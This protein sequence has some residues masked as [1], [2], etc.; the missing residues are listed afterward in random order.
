MRRLLLTL[1][2]VAMTVAVVAVA[3]RVARADEADAHYRSGLA[4]KKQNKTDEAIQEFMA[5]IKLRS[6]Y[7]AA[8]FSLGLTYKMRNQLAKA[9]DLN[10][11]EA[12]WQASLGTIYREKKEFGK[13]IPHLEKA[14]QLD[15]KDAMALS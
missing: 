13:A 1:A 10:P 15:P 11:N 4:L 9:I 5:A 12:S 6:D 8:E 7:A 2:A 3:P 14:V